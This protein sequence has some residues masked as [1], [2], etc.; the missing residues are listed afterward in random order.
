MARKVKSC[1]EKKWKRE[2]NREA[3]RGRGERIMN[4]GRTG[5]IEEEEEDGKVKGRSGCM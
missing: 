4:G 1:G 5:T 3:I 2:G